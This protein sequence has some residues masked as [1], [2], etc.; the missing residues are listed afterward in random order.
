MSYSCVGF[1][2][3]YVVLGRR[4]PR[5]HRQ[6]TVR[7]CSTTLLGLCIILKDTGHET[8]SVVEF[9]INMGSLLMSMVTRRKTSLDCFFFFFFFL[10]HNLTSLSVPWPIVTQLS[11]TAI[12]NNGKFVKRL[13]CGPKFW[14]GT[15]ITYTMYIDVENVLRNLASS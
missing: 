9:W 12:N 7:T 6:P 14:L 3:I 13:P 2:F 5:K 11:K 15:N 1:R 10:L 4:C 8:D